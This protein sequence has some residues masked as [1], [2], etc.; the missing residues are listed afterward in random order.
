MFRNPRRFIRD[1]LFAAAGLGAVLLL[2]QAVVSR[3]GAPQGA[4]SPNIILI[5]IDTLRADHVGCYGD[6]S[7]ATPNI[8]ALAQTGARFT[9]AYT[10]VPLTLPAHASLMTGSFPMATG[11]HDFTTNKLPSSSVTLAK[12]LRDN[13]FTT[14][15]FIASAVL[16][17]RFGLNQGF[18]T[19]FDHF[20]FR[21]L[22]GSHFDEWERRGDVVVDEVVSWLKLNPRQ[23]FFLWVHLYD[24]HQPYTPPEPY[25]SRFRA[26]P[27]DGEIAFADVQVGRLFAYLRERQIYENALIVLASDHGEGLGEHGEKTHGFFIYNSTLH[28]PLIFKVPGAAARVVEEDVSL[29][30]VMPTILQALQLRIPPAAQG[31]SLLSPILGRPSG[32]TSNLYAETY[33]PLLHFHWS[34]LR[35]LQSRGWKY[36]E[37]PKPE[38][39]DVRNDPSERKN[40]LA[41]R[42]ALARE[43]G[44]QLQG[45]M[46]QYTPAGGPKV[47][48]VLTDPALYDRLRALGYVAVSAGTF[49]EPSGKPL[50]DPKDRIET[51]DLLSQ[52]MA[53]GQHGQYQE[54]LRKLAEAAKAEPDSPAINYMMG[55]DYQNM[56]ELPKAFEHFQAALKVNPDFATALYYLGVTQAEEGDLDGA[57]GSL[58]RAIE[59]DP[60]NFLAV[61]E[62]G[63]IHLKKGSYD[64]AF[65]EFQRTVSLNPDYAPAQA[66]VGE[67]Y[68]HQGKP[69]EA[70]KELERAVELDPQSRRS[71]YSLGLA[72][73]AL[74]RN[75][76]AQREFERA[77]AP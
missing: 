59:L 48:Q 19:Y 1:G 74:G 30:D 58:A 62:L 66:A 68:L 77:K 36:I 15:A 39:Y 64:E 63:I 9:H 42:G 16:D 28:V 23:P 69:D 37:A 50:A 8:D 34:Q 25:A 35:A 71:R 73:Q 57:A 13:G 61:F 24:P 46:R 72:Y 54:S 52:A 3:G 33:L 12:V 45:L 67:G 21:E 31:R 27:Y 53:D 18:D 70:V 17:S 75:A 11:M 32:A 26:S 40:L 65:Q 55:L 14:A 47:G 22:H 7:A 49:A 51:Y 76:D 10:P 2:L 44:E 29:V 43:M 56:H 38:L 4:E 60:T 5:T 20:D 41:G 6:P